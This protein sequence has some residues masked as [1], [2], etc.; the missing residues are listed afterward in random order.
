MFIAWLVPAIPRAR[1]FF[2]I[3]RAQKGE[4]KMKSIFKVLE[5]AAIFSFVIYMTNGYP[6]IEQLAHK[7]AA[8]YQKATREPVPEPTFLERLGKALGLR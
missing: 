2:A 3:V 1:V 6:K 5:W 7:T 4:K 8:Y